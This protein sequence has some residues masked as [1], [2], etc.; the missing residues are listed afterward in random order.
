[1]NFNINTLAIVLSLTN[2]MQVILMLSQFRRNKT[3]EGPGWWTLGGA[4]AALGFA[5]YAFRHAAAPFDAIAIVFNNSFLMAALIFVYIGIRHYQGLHSGGKALSIFG[6]AVFFLNIYFTLP[7]SFSYPARRIILFASITVISFATAISLIK[8]KGIRF[9]LWSKAVT[10]GFIAFGGFSL[11]GVAGTISVKELQA[12][13]SAELL[14]TAMFVGTFFV[15][16]VWTFGFLSLNNRRLSEE[17]RSAKER[18][19]SIFNTSPD[20]VFI[21]SIADGTIWNINEGFTRLTGYT[22]EETIGKTSLDINLYQNV[23][24]R[25]FI[26]NELV[27]KGICENFETNINKKN[28]ELITVLIS[29]KKN[30]F[31][32]VPHDTCVIRD[33]SDRKLAED[34]VRKS[35]ERY[36]LLFENAVEAVV[37]TQFAK[38]RLC[39]PMAETLTGYTRDELLTLSITKFIHPEDLEFAIKSHVNRPE[40]GN[41]VNRFDFRV[42]SKSNEVKWVETKSIV[43]EWDEQP[44]TLNFLTDIT[45]RKKA[46]QALVE[47]ETKYRLITEFASDVI[48]VLNLTKDQYTYMSPSV[49]NLRGYTSEEAMALGVANSFTSDSLQVVRYSLIKNLEHFKQNPKASNHYINEL[50]QTCKNGDVIWVEESTKYRYNVEGEV[51][52]VGVTR[53]IEDRKK[54]ESEILYLS[55]HDQLTGLKNR[56]FFDEIIKELEKKKCLPLALIMADVNGLKLTNDA[57][58]HRAG[59]VVLTT[60]ANTLKNQCRSCDYAARIGGDE[61]VLLLPETDVKTA[62]TILAHINSAIAEEQKENMVISVSI[63]LAVRNKASEEIVEIFKKAEDDMY[64]Q[65]LAESSSLR[66]KTIDLIMNTLYEKNNREMLHSKRVGQLCELIAKTLN[67]ESNAVN[68]LRLAGLMHDIGKIGIDEKILNDKSSLT[69]DEWVEVKRHTEIGYR[70]LSSVNEFSEI[71]DCIL[72]HHEHWDGTG[73]PRGLKGEEISLQGRVISLADAYDAMTSDRTY[74]EALSEEDAVAEIAACAGTQFDPELA[75]IFIEKVLNNPVDT[76]NDYFIQSKKA[77]KQ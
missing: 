1:M 17:S 24:D 43:I 41:A 23:S 3:N 70:I 50:Q 42:L 8:H 46:V 30:I 51:E 76:G 53:N 22:R 65:K 56:R 16:T 67:L 48:W 62:E 38:I 52:I 69:K 36:H 49:Y 75:K 55:Y 54:T 39:N 72:E 61:F 31:N 66:S 71:A 34:K 64:R 57:F 44:A 7:A 58:G 12:P 21:S 68:Q 14:Q 37:V 9:S 60:V 33:I 40:E 59:D 77:D 47:S 25:Q 18:F 19:E 26:Y 11:A 74:R 27:T 28:G 13:D 20:G 63:G 32:G 10:A 29:S 73:Y 2:V 5:L 45:E 35:S 4:S 6:T 15:S